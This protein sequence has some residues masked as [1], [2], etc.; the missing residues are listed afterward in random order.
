MTGGLYDPDNL[1]SVALL[2]LAA[3]WSQHQGDL[4]RDTWPSTTTRPA[5]RVRASSLA[6]LSVGQ[7]IVD[8]IVL[9]QWQTAV[10][11]LAA[12][13]SL[14]QVAVAIGE[15]A[16]NA[17]DVARRIEFWARDQ[18]DE[19]RISAAEYATIRRLIGDPR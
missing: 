5:A 15:E 6:A 11:A 8:R 2:D 3:A 16:G 19:G 14:D 13:A 4:A 1:A 18:R 17:D 9:A 7:A 12:G 10:R